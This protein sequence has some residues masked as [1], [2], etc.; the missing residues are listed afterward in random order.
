MSLFRILAIVFLGATIVL[1]QLTPDQKTIDFQYL[2]SLYAKR[3]AP[4]EWKRDVV[5]FDLLNIGPWLTRISATT[6]DLQFFDI[7]SEYVSS[8]NDA[9]DVY[10]LPSN[11]VAN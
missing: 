7:M 1:G 5:K 11:F 3:Y 4:Y 9:H 2:A 10:T 8:L 6:N